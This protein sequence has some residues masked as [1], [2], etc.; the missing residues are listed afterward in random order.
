MLTAIVM[1]AAAL[2]WWRINAFHDHIVEHINRMTHHLEGTIM[3]SQQDAVNAVTAQI[4][5]GTSEVLGRIAA[6]QEQVDSGVPAEDLDLSGLTAA[7]Q[8]LDDIVVDAPVEEPVEEP[9]V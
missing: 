9:T 6:L 8:A 7:A 4:K 5:K 3:S 2:T 1:A